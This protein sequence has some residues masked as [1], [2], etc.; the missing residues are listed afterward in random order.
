MQAQLISGKNAFINEKRGFYTLTQP[1]T[2]AAVLVRDT[3]IG[4]PKIT[5][6]LFDHMDAVGKLNEAPAVVVNSATNVIAHDLPLILNNSQ[7]LANFVGKQSPAS[8]PKKYKT[9]PKAQ[10]QYQNGPTVE[11]NSTWSGHKFSAEEIRK[12]LQGDVI[13]FSATS[14]YGKTYTATGALKQQ[15]FKGKKF[16]GFKA[17]FGK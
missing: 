5:K 9:K 11:F 14:K 4:S 17:D 7:E 13:S 2:I 3:W 16:W 15:T 1:G 6:Q 8:A 12:L 10:G